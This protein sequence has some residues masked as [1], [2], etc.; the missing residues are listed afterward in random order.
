MIK[1]WVKNRLLFELII[2]AVLSLLFSFA[3]VFPSNYNCAKIEDDDSIYLNSNIDFQIPSPSISQLGEI[4]SKPFV[5]DTFGYYLTKTNI[6]G[7]NNSNINLLMSNQMDSLQLTMFNDSTKIASY[8]ESLI[9]NIAFLDEIAAKKLNVGVG[10]ELTIAI[11]GQNLKYTTSTIFRKNM[12][13]SEGTIIVDF[14]GD[15]K[16]IYESNLSSSSYS[17]A[18]ISVSDISECEKYLKSYV[19][20]GR[21]KD[22]SE[23]DSDEAYDIYT[24]AIMSGDY[25]NEITNF[26]KLRNIAIS[27]L[28]SAKL[29]RRLFSYI[30][31]ISIGIVYFIM[32][33]I[34]RSRKSENKYFGNVLKNK[35]SIIT[36]RIC[37]LVT[38]TSIFLMLSIVIQLYMNTISITII[39][40]V[41]STILF[42]ITYMINITLDKS[43]VK[44][45][46]YK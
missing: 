40:I 34:L 5:N 25:S 31:A 11:A 30:G 41:I 15:I 19:P 26:S 10:D 17:G 44:A 35:K 4:K 37:S 24:N 28:K 3:F 43:Y 6:I 16:S 36:Y 9:G 39:P 8:S 42:I 22:R 1:Y 27:E 45:K 14:V 2:T 38:N 7:K 13:F 46:R 32:T 18:F 33:M 23:F 20:L 21:L 12:L 29:N